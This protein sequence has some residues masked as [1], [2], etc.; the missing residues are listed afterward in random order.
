MIWTVQRICR[1]K[2]NGV[3]EFSSEAQNF[4]I[5]LV[6]QHVRKR[7]FRNQWFIVAFKFNIKRCYRIVIETVAHPSRSPVPFGLHSF[8]W[9]YNIFLIIFLGLS[10]QNTRRLFTLFCYVWYEP[11]RL[12]TCI[13]G[14]SSV[15]RTKKKQI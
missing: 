14:C 15:Q 8:L 5:F 3:R 12:Y 11:W 7:F 6:V 2:C 13:N 4:E 9:S 10:G 1:L